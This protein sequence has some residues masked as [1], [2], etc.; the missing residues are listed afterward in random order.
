MPT[1]ERFR[2]RYHFTAPQNWINDPNGLVQ[3][4]GQYH[5]FYQHNPGAA[6][7]GDMHWGHAVSSDLLNWEHLP[8]A[9]FPDEDYDR[10]GVYSG[11]AINTG[12]EVQFLYTGV[13]GKDELPCI[14]TASDDLLLQ[15]VKSENNPIFQKPNGLDLVIFRDHAVAK[16]EDTWYQVIGSGVHGEGPNC[17]LYRSDDLQSWEFLHPLVNP[18]DLAGDDPQVTGW[19]CPDFFPLGDTWVLIVS[20]WAEDPIR[21]WAYTGSFDGERFVPRQGSIVDTGSAF[22][23]P[24]SFTDDAGR[25]IQFGWLKETRPVAQ[26]S[27]DGWAGAMSIPR[28]LF[29]R[30]DGTLG[31]KPVQEVLD[32]LTLVDV[33]PASSEDW[34]EI[35]LSGIDSTRCVLRIDAGDGFEL[36]LLRSDD[37]EEETSVAFNPD[38]SILKIDTTR[39]SSNTEIP[40]ESISA[41]LPGASEFLVF[42]D[43]SVVEIYADG[44]SH[45]VRVYPER[46]DSTGIRIRSRGDLQ[47]AASELRAEF[48]AREATD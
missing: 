4:K 18:A 24:Q 11:I 20:H 43:R 2:P 37:G 14:A 19:E 3:W 29:I 23:A 42:V 33:A 25:R 38:S 45:T 30:P 5:L 9:L 46:M 21:V 8:I 48:T 40:G 35:E 15:P 26:H 44:T 28:E 36:G 17:M 12:H 41:N 39:S 22:Y 32:A 27:A 10:D 34:S 7:W 6:Y 47:I 1:N 31:V 16:L 13:A